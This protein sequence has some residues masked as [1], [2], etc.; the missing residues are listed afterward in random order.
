MSIHLPK[1]P[2]ITAEAAAWVAGTEG[3]V[4]N[5]MADMLSDGRADPDELLMLGVLQG[6]ANAAA[7]TISELN[8]AEGKILENIVSNLK[9]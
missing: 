6:D 8:Q 3:A 4:N 7:I 5:A 9:A 1:G 2:G